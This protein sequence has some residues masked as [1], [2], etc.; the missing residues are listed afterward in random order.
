MEL[1]DIYDKDRR[2]TGRQIERGQKLGAGEYHTTVHVAIFTPDG[3]LLK[4]TASQIADKSGSHGQAGEV[5]SLD[6]GITVACGTGAVTLLGV[7]PEGKGRM[8]AMDFIRGRKV[9]VGDI[10]N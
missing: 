8:S 3:R 9:N 4:I 10:L 1:W 2:L 5:I 7:V 6:G